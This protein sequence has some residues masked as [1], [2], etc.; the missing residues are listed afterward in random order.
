MKGVPDAVD[1]EVD[2]KPLDRVLGARLELVPELL[3]VRRRKGRRLAQQ[4]RVVVFPNV[5]FGFLEVPPQGNEGSQVVVE[6][7]AQ[8]SDLGM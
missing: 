4:L 7:A 8:L 2:H 6:P 1:V 5:R 3:Q